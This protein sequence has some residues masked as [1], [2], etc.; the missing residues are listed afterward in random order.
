MSKIVF[1]IGGTN[2]RVARVEGESIAN[3]LK[4]PTP[5][6]ATKGVETLIEVIRQISS[7]DEIEAVFGGMAGVISP[8]GTVLKSPNL[9]GWDGFELGKRL[10]GE[11]DGNVSIRNDAALAGLAEAVRGAGRGKSIV[12]YLG[13]GT[14]VGGV[15]IV[16]GKIDSASSGFE[17][18]HHIIDVS[19]KESFENKVSGRAIKEKYG[20]R[21]K[22]LE[23]NV[24]DEL[25]TALAT[26]VYNVILLWS[27]EVIILGGPLIDENEG[28]NI[29]DIQREIEKLPKVFPVLPELRKS[30]LRDEAGLL[31]AMI[32]SEK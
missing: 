23:K 14:G 6:N 24:Y 18:G 9:P 8:E 12:A 5:H 1:D 28:F 17:P 29:G 30:V 4:L 15:R 3:V 16:G 25:V 19:K 26:G 11:F 2:M 31:G 27:P 32:I 22:E 7:D 21:L 20:K 13:V 10:R